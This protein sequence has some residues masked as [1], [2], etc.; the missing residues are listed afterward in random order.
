MSTSNVESKSATTSELVDLPLQDIMK[1]KGS[2]FMNVITEL[3]EQT[4][5]PNIG[6][7]VDAFK[8]TI[9]YVA[10]RLKHK[11][12]TGERYLQ[13]YKGDWRGGTK[14]LLFPIDLNQVELIYISEQVGACETIMYLP[15]MDR[16][17]VCIKEP[18]PASAP[19]QTYRPRGD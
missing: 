1:L 16:Y 11:L 10:N 17:T 12:P 2:D 5:R 8:L 14:P 19:K 18:T 15:H 7:L 9:F 4:I 6:E 3:V 13:I